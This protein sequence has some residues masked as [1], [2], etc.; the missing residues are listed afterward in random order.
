MK[1][2][3]ALNAYRARKRADQARFYAR[4]RDACL[5]KNRS[6]REQ[7]RQQYK[8]HK[9]RYNRLPRTL[10]FSSIYQQI[11]REQ[12]VYFCIRSNL[13][14]RINRAIQN[15]HKRGSAVSDLG[16]SIPEFKTYIESKFLPGMSWDN[17][18][19]DTWHLDH[20]KPLASFDLTDREQFLQACH[21]TNY[22]P[23]WAVD[24]LKKGAR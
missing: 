19:Q 13:R 23:L 15:G 7:N 16:C 4:N 5:A 10:F 3:E 24:N 12:D 17:W 20:V 14:R 6:W 22:Q 21:Y 2:E 18:A 11:R 8:E 1:S 9:A